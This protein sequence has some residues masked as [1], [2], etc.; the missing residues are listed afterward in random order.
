M[1][2]LESRGQPIGSSQPIGSKRPNRQP[3]GSQPVRAVRF[4]PVLNLGAVRLWG[5]KARPN[6]NRSFRFRSRYIN[7]TLTEV[8]RLGNRTF[9]RTS[10]VTQA[11]EV[12]L[13]AISNRNSSVGLSE[14]VRL[15]DPGADRSRPRVSVFP[16][17]RIT[18]TSHHLGKG[19][20][21]EI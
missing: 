5:A 3:L 10:S 11:T 8:V 9:D 6:L 7:R 16:P 20:C 4:K 13:K 19:G 17:L 18:P 1:S 21:H 2:W 15:T 14:P 12:R